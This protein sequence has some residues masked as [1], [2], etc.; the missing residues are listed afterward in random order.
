MGVQLALLRSLERLAEDAD[1]AH[2]IRALG[3][4][5]VLLA[6][7]SA[8]GPAPRVARCAARQRARAASSFA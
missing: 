1:G 5:N 7:L 8:P 2:E 4:I 6:L 3:G